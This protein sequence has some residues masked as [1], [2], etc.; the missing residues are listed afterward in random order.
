MFTTKAE[1]ADRYGQDRA[2][3]ADNLQHG[4]PFGGASPQTDPPAGLDP[5]AR[6]AGNPSGRWKP[7]PP[8]G[9]YIVLKAGRS[10]VTVYSQRWRELNSVYKEKYT[11]VLSNDCDGQ[12]PFTTSCDCQ[13]WVSG[14]QV[15][16]CKHMMSVD[17][18]I[19]IHRQASVRAGRQ[20]RRFFTWVDR[21]FAPLPDGAVVV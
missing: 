2:T 11:V 16:H 20:S 19:P 17:D 13:D 18:I 9:K 4:T 3:R 21:T 12:N 6:W 10:D 5:P 8:N 14:R 15:Q 7:A 1:W